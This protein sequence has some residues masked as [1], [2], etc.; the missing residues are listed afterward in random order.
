MV[1]CI[2]KK[3]VI[4]IHD[5]VFECFFLFV[6]FFLYHKPLI[7]HLFR[8][9]PLIFYPLSLQVLRIHFIEELFIFICMILLFICFVFYQPLLYKSVSQ[10]PLRM[11]FYG[12]FVFHVY[13]Y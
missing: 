4:K 6:L 11:Y 8:Q 7:A 5:N 12:Y 13:T 2:F 9:M 1:N 10:D 3:C